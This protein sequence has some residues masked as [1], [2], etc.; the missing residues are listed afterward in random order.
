VSASDARA[1]PTRRSRGVDLAL[2]IGV[3][4]AL[5]AASLPLLRVVDSGAWVPGAF[6]LTAVVLGAGYVARWFR[7]PGL[8]VSL[9]EI[10]VWV[11]LVTAVFGRATAFLWV[12]PTTD[13]FSLAGV[14]LSSAF[15]DVAL[16]AAPLQAGP[17]LSFLLVASIGLLAIALDHVV[18]TA[19]MPLLAAVGLIAVSLIPSI[20]VP[21]D[22]DIAAF[23][24]LAASI[25]FLLGVDTRAR[26]RAA[27]VQAGGDD[28]LVGTARV[29][30]GTAIG[31]GAI[32]IVI[33]MVASPL[34][35]A[36]IAIAG[37]AG[38]IGGGSTIDPSLELG[39]DLRQPG[40]V[41]VL[42]LTTTAARAP[43]VRVATLSQFDGRVW[44]PD[45]G[46]TVPL[47]GEG[48][49]LDVVAVDEGIEI[50]D[51]RATIDI[52]NLNSR[53]APVAYPATEV[54]GLDGEWS[55]LPDNRT[56]DADT[57][58]VQA[59]DYE[60]VTARPDPTLEQIRA[61]PAG[62]AVDDRLY[63]LPDEIPAIIR[64][65][66]EEVTADTRSD[67][68]AL[69]A[70]QAWFRGSSFS[71]SLEAPV[72]DGFDGTG[73]ESLA[74]FINIREGYCVHFAAAFAVMART[75]G[76]PSRIVVGYLP[77]TSTGSLT[78]GEVVYSV[79]STQL[80]AWPEVHFEGIGWVPFEPT[81]S[82]G[83]PTNF[84]SGASTAPG[85][86]P[87]SAPRPETALPTP[88]PTSSAPGSLADE[89][90]PGAMDGGGYAA[91]VNYWPLAG[92]ILALLLL[93]APGTFRAVRRRRLLAA[94]G[95]GDATAAWLSIQELAID[96]G[97]PVPASESPRAFGERLVDQRG[98][99]PEAMEV[100]VRAIERVSYSGDA[101]DEPATGWADAVTATSASLLDTVSSG[102]RLMARVLPRSLAIRPGSAYAG[103]RPPP[104][105]EKT[106]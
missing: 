76:M 66:A 64:E 106:A 53:W 88:T 77:G 89:R 73:V 26:Q 57:G 19:R 83:T 98:A 74:R 97:I 23:I 38:G 105:R 56:V 102:R 1:L 18:L 25:L 4:V 7:L 51:A 10:V 20:A 34:L 87:S 79:Q 42:Q 41:E 70:L 67:Y 5:F 12:I 99:D 52:V 85:T 24:A 28:P 33:A 36:P 92:T 45:E 54:S 31:I 75:L 104:V 49:D 35:P 3:L 37:G 93:A 86:T 27:T 48:P 21:G 80:H 44:E 71:Y 90:D 22:V 101:G 47:N 6:A 11:A 16:G 50:E 13:T 82:L 59:Q 72:S 43:Y 17:A 46:D 8:V 95:R 91:S 55:I 84:T 94:A 63:D 2:A 40:A 68:D 14:L 58:T 29:P 15:E 78:D 9:V 100:L 65:T 81:N 103:L 69:I 39:D 62:G 96:L 30:S 61:R 60:I 32:A